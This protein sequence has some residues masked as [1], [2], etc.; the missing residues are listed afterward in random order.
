MGKFNRFLSAVNTTYNPSFVIPNFARDLE[1][2]GINAQEYDEKG[3]TKEVMK[4][5]PSAVIGIGKLLFDKNAVNKWTDIYKE[6]VSA[7]GKNAT[8]QMGDVKDQIDN[9]DNI[10]GDISD[11]GIKQK[12]GLNRNQFVGKNARSL[13]SMLDNA[14]TAVE[15]GVRVSLYKSLRDRGVSKSRAALAARNITVNFAKGGENKAV[16]NSMYLFYNASLQGSM[17]LVNAATRSSKVR[18][19]WA[20]LMVYGIMQDTINGLFSGDEDEDGISDYDEIPRHILEH[21]IIVPTLGLTGDKHITIPMAYGLNMAVNFGRSLSRMGRGEYTPG[22]AMKSIV[23]TTVESISPIGAYD[24][25]LNFAAPTVF[26]P[27]I[28]VGINEDYKGDPIYKESPTYASVAKA[29]SS[30]Y[31]SNTSSIAKTIASSVNSLTGGDDIKGG[32]I[33]MSPDIIEYW[34]G[35][36]TGGAG[37]F[38]MRSLEAPVDIYDAL[39]GDFEGSLINSIPLARKV[40][41]TPS[42]RADTGNYLDNRQDLFTLMAQ[43]DMAKRSGDK[44]AVTSIYENNK[45]QISIV[46]RMKAIDNAR[47]RMQRQIKEIERNPRIP[48]DT[49]TKIIRIRRDKINELQQMGLI[50]M[51]SAGYKKAG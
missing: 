42:P 48:E 31:W 37:R 35:T 21:N 22:E 41:T 15:N 36:F 19:M 3:F 27:F 5:T 25:F 6:F 46:G 9:I 30:Q 2:A 12:L 29:N 7:G 17:A 40:I 43:L 51:R 11:S 44:E 4:G 33:D 34:F 8:N 16:M 13:L 49:K 18:K 26:D 10:I 20:G 23:G 38:A 32:L 28:S 14:N 50:L 47:N 39:Q 45:K 24:N 1:T